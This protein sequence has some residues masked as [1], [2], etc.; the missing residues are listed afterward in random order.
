M[1]CM[2]SNIGEELVTGCE[3]V[4]CACERWLHEMCVSGVE[5]NIDGKELL[6]P[7]CCV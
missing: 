1:F 5:V 3:W 6:C 2:P 4:E 7:F